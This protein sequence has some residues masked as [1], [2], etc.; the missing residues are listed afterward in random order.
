MNVCGF[1]QI[2]GE[3]F[4]SSSISALVVNDIT[5]CSLFVL[6]L[7]SVGGTGEMVHV[8]GAFLHGSFEVVEQIY[9]KVPKGGFGHNHEVYFTQGVS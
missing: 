4:D 2:D 7:M 6:M 9:M 1:H 8:K 3:H 5:I